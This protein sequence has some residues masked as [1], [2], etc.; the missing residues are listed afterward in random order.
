MRPCT[1]QRLDSRQHASIAGHGDHPRPDARN[2]RHQLAD[3]LTKDGAE[4]SL[5]SRV[6]ALRTGRAHL[7]ERSNLD[8]TLKELKQ[9]MK[10]EWRE[11]RANRSRL[12]AVTA[13]VHAEQQPRPR[14]R[15]KK[16]GCDRRHVIPGGARQV[17]VNP[18]KQ[19]FIPTTATGRPIQLDD[20]TMARRP[21]V[22]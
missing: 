17:H 15:R 22:K 11:A 16:P 14:L 5:S 2:A 7:V 12:P 19:L 13:D 1:P 9:E 3:A 8:W 6:Y 4:A 18:R 21:V 20:L 10:S